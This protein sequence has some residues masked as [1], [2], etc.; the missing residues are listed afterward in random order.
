MMPKKVS[1]LLYDQDIGSAV[2]KSQMC[3]EKDRMEINAAIGC[4]CS[5]MSALVSAL[6]RDQDIRSVKILDHDAATC[7][8]AHRDDGRDNKLEAGLSDLQLH[9]VSRW[10]IL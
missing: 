4:W 6:M 1:A 2:R 10:L 3:K 8:I 5:A 7:V 9:W